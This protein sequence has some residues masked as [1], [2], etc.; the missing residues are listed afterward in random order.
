V[1]LGAAVGQMLGVAVDFLT[2]LDYGNLL[3]VIGQIAICVV[4][5]V[6]GFIG[7]L[8]LGLLPGIG[9]GLL[10]IGKGLWDGCKFLLVAINQTIIDGLDL[11]PGGVGKIFAMGFE[12]LNALLLN[13]WGGFINYIINA[14]K[15]GLDSLKQLGETIIAP[16]RNIPGFANILPAPAPGAATPAAPT[17]QVGGAMFAGHVPNAAGGLIDAARRESAAMPRNAQIVVA[18]SKEY[19][20]QPRG[21]TR[22]GAGG[23]TY[24]ININGSNHDP[25][26]IAQMVIEA[27]E[28]TFVDEAQGQLG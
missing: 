20:L 15:A 14:L 25:N 10:N 9:Q 18:N 24:Q 21:T 22:V 17:P 2:K 12:A 26:M 19:I 5:A 11:L 6:S 4:A 3:V 23:N 8:A 7:G 16:L 27:I 1:A 28:Q 13:G